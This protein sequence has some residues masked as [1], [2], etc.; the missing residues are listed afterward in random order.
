M[1][2]KSQ[3]IF[4]T[5]QARSSVGN[6]QRTNSEHSSRLSQKKNQAYVDRN[7]ALQ[8]VWRIGRKGRCSVRWTFR[9]NGETRRQLNDYEEL[10]VPE[11]LTVWY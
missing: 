10:E 1:T 2:T 3:P 6:R 8:G 4:I 7:A 5:N 11:G 9:E